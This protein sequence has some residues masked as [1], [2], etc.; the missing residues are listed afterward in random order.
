M[1]PLFKKESELKSYACSYWNLWFINHKQTYKHLHQTP[2]RK[3]RLVT[4]FDGWW[5]PRSQRSLYPLAWQFGME[6]ASSTLCA[7][8]HSR[9]FILSCQ[10]LQ[11]FPSKGRLSFHNKEHDISVLRV[12]KKAGA[13]AKL[14]EEVTAAPLEEILSARDSRIGKSSNRAAA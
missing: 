4:V 13:L 6:N 3:A 5:S 8:E 12:E 1:S 7:R 14:S 10:S 9:P 2:W 11:L